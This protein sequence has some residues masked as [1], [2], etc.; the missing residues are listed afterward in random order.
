MYMGI[1]VSAARG[2]DACVLDERRRVSLLGAARDLD[3][4]ETLLRGLPRHATIAVDAPPRPSRDLVPGREYRVAERD[5]H[6]L[7]ISLYPTPR[8]ES[9]AKEWMRQGFALFRLLG[10]LGFPLYLHGDAGRGVAVEVYPHLSY[11]ALTGARRGKTSKLEW[12]RAALRR[13]VGGLPAVATQDQLDAACAALTAWHF[14][15]G[16]WV[17]YGDPTEGLIV[18][19]QTGHDLSRLRAAARDQ[20]EL[21]IEAGPGR[22]QLGPLRQSTFAER[23][24]RVV[25]QIPSGK[26]ATYGDVARWAGNPAGARAVG[27][28]MARHAFEVPCHRVVDSRGAPPPF[29]EEAPRMLK[30]EGIP[31]DGGRVR[32]SEARWRGPG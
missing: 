14:V 15:A 25:A 16:R 23:V 24:L 28:L 19:P 7:G 8:S 4:L 21:P 6:A 20:L 11:L 12:S 29:R 22:R 26:V 32:L 3:A 30:R 13:R 17:G 27:T 1:D 10:K 5:L 9:R 18:A 31:F 2:F